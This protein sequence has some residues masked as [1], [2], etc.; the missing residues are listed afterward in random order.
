MNVCKMTSTIVNSR[1]HGNES[2]AVTKLRDK[3]G[4]KVGFSVSGLEEGLAHDAAL[5]EN[6]LYIVKVYHLVNMTRV[7]PL[8][9]YAVSRLNNSQDVNLERLL[10]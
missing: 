3:F 10:E 2:I 9:E 7:L 5:Y 4:L 1:Y 6:I 8:L